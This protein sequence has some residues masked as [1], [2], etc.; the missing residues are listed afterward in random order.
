MSIYAEAINFFGVAHQVGKALEEIAE[1]KEA[2]E[3]FGEGK[4]TKDHVCEEIADVEIMCL[5]LRIMFGNDIV[6]EWKLKKIER[7]KRLVSDE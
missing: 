5:Q 7:L 6:D 3:T 1:L 4:D 2:I